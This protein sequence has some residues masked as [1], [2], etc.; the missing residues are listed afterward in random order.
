MSTL[1]RLQMSEAA[2][3]ETDWTCPMAQA[4]KLVTLFMP[5]IA[6]TFANLDQLDNHTL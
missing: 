2:I 4:C 6:G 5:A 3:L 1:L